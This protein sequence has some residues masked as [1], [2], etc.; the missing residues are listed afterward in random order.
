M[1]DNKNLKNYYRKSSFVLKITRYVVTLLFIFFIIFTILLFG[2]DVTI[3]NVQL[4]SKFISI[5]DGSSLFYT[6]EFTVTAS[7]DSESFMLRDNLGIVNGNNF[8]LYYLSGQKLFSYDLSY[9]FPAVLFNEHNILIYDIGGNKASIYNSFSKIKSFDFDF[10]IINA[11]ITKDHLAFVTA[12]DSNKSVITVYE[13]VSSKN[14]YIEVYKY[15]S[16]ENYVT[17]VSLSS[18]GEHLLV[19][20]ADSLSGSFNC[21]VSVF[22]IYSDSSTPVH[23]AKISDELVLN[24]CFTNKSEIYVITDSGIVFYNSSLEEI[25]K[26]TFNQSKTSSYFVNDDMIMVTERNNLSGNSMLLNGIDFS[27]NVLFS[28]NAD[29]EI[30]DISFGKDKFFALG[31]D[32]IYE[33]S[34]DKDEGFKRSGVYLS[35][36]RFNSIVTDTDNNCY[37]VGNSYVKRITFED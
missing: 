21:S 4:L 26:F 2:K 3:E 15:F 1:N 32:G 20:Y 11:Y 9:A 13:Y 25:N 6:D 18:S 23:S 17:S 28:I 12:D 37:V 8:S 22:D 7:D 19:T 30:H 31:E 16:S 35:N 33:Y 29:D 10:P 14:N 24:A 34:A 36:T 5:N 27:G